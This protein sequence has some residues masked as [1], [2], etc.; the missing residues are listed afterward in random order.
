MMPRLTISRCMAE[1]PFGVS[2]RKPTAGRSKS[3]QICCH[4]PVPMIRKDLASRSRRSKAALLEA[5]STSRESTEVVIEGLTAEEAIRYPEYLQLQH[6]CSPE[7]TDDH[8]EVRLSNVTELP[9]TLRSVVASISMVD[10]LRETRVMSGFTR[11]MSERVE[12]APSPA[13]HMWKD[14]PVREDER[15]LPA[16]VIYGEGIFVRFEEEPLKQWEQQ[17]KVLEHIRIDRY[18]RT[19]TRAWRVP[20]KPRAKR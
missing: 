7:T 8:L 17:A 5:L 1:T 3:A 13:S 12:G 4:V 6:A 11:L 10:R 15:W 9:D 18:A 14:A 16:A 2:E 19:R 20:I